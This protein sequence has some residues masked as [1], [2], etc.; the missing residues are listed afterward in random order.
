MQGLGNTLPHLKRLSPKRGASCVAPP[1]GLLA[2]PSLGPG[3][4]AFL[5]KQ[6]HGGAREKASPQ[7][8]DLKTSHKIAKETGVSHATIERDAQLTQAVEDLEE[9]PREIE[10][11]YSVS[12][13]ST[14][15]LR[16]GP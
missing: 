11:V 15:V 10:R 16:N 12:E 8:E 4:G 13:A 2:K 6:S 5:E 9:I 7:N 1:Q 14:Y 3:P